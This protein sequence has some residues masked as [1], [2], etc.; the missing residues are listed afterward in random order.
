MSLARVLLANI[1]I[2]GAPVLARRREIEVLDRRKTDRVLD[3][4]QGVGGVLGRM[5]GGHGGG[6]G[7][8]DETG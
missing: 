3:W 5:G 2:R 8:S 4:R 7:G 1:A 6:G